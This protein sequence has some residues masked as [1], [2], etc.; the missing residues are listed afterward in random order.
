MHVILQKNFIILAQCDFMRMR[1][2]SVNN[3]YLSEKKEKEYLHLFF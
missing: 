1:R 3:L 2:L